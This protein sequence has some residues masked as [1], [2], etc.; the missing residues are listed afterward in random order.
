M[1]LNDK[2]VVF[3]EGVL[4]ESLFNIK[5]ENVAHIFSILRSQLYSDKI[6]AIIREYITNAI[7]A[8]TEANVTQPITITVPNGLSNEFIVRD[9]GFGL[10]KEDVIN[11]FASYGESTKRN[12]NSFTGMLGIGSKSAFAYASSFT[13]ISRHKGIKTIYQAYIDESNVGKIAEINSQPTTETGLSVHVSIERKDINQF[14]NTLTQFFRF[15]D[16]RPEFKGCQ[17]NIPDLKYN[18]SGSFWK[19]YEVTNQNWR[20][21]K[22]V[23]FV[24][25]NVTYKSTLEILS[26]QLIIDLKWLEHFYNSA[27]IVDVPIG[28]I[29]P[30][31][32]RESIEFNEATKQYIRDVLYDIKLQLINKMREKFEQCK[33]LYEKHCLAYEFVNNFHDITPKEIKS[34]SKLIDCEFASINRTDE[35]KIKH[36]NKSFPYVMDKNSIHIMPNSRFIVYHQGQKLTHITQR[37]T[38]YFEGLP[39]QDTMQN[40]V[41]IKFNNQDYM[42][43]FINHPS[44]LGAEFINA[45]TLPFT[46]GINTALKS[47]DAKLY[48]FHY[49]R[50]LNLEIW[51]PA[52]ITPS[53]NAIYVEISSFKPKR[54]SDNKYIDDVIT[55]LDCIEIRVPT[56]FGVKTSEL[57]KVVQPDWIELKDYLIQKINEWKLNNPNKVR[58]YEYFKDASVFQKELISDF[59]YLSHLKTNLDEYYRNQSNLF[60]VE[61]ALAKFNIEMFEYKPPKEFEQ[62]YQRYPFMQSFHCTMSYPDKMR[63]IKY[64]DM[65]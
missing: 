50:R 9:Y 10:S 57:K 35:L 41:L 2:T 14:H 16:Y 19:F 8:H 55:Y 49:G 29:K 17:I 44:I 45:E 33:S 65:S 47:E 42:D 4:N 51:Q 52:K 60:H 31:A 3:A 6:G 18:L 30:S 36:I 48:Q 24:M 34:Y 54:Y 13:V 61:V 62:L 7:D 25:G 21:A 23:N 26:N 58:D 32:S 28:K 39:T 63:L 59:K 11:I 20:S 1:I 46:R 38:E 27:L 22:E 43:R 64:L 56:V 5:Q 40:L 53:D 15:I 12:S 37:M